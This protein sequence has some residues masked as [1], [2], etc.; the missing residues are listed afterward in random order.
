MSEYTAKDI[1]R[2]LR[3]PKHRYQYLATRGFAISPSILK[4]QGQ[5]LANVYSAE[6]L[7]SFGIANALLNFGFHKRL[8]NKVL[9]GQP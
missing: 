8:I 4:D 9:T 2:I 7:V 6:D 1:Q 3:I 5:G